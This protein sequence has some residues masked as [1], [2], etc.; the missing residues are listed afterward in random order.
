[1][2]S[3]EACRRRSQS[4]E[5]V[6][7]V[8]RVVRARAGL[9]VVLDRR[10]RDVPQ[11]Q[12]LDRAVVE[13]EM[14][15]LGGAELR[16]PAHR[17]VGLD[18]RLAVGP[19]HREPVVLRR[20]LDPARIEILHRV[21]RAP[22]A[23]RELEGLEADRPAQQLMPEADAHHRA[24]AD[25]LAHRVDDVVE[26]RRVPGAVGEEHQV[27]VALKH[28]LGGRVQGSNVTRHT[29]LRNCSIIERLIPVSIATTR[30][31]SPSSKLIGSSASRSSRS[32]SPS[33]G[34]SASTCSRASASAGPTGKDPATH[35]AHIAIRRLKQ[36][37]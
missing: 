37:T 29:R 13:V 8:A 33:I 16:L 14:G 24:L 22:V 31:P 12:A 28:L 32:P 35:R 2:S 17:L 9:R 26:R 30:G 10:A 20:D 27:G 21:V 6:E 7:Q 36:T 23:E 19:L 25:D 3:R 4:H 11:D 34:G 18:P 1:M 15:E 5:A